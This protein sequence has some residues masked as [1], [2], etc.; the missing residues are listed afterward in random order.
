MF[1]FEDFGEAMKLMVSWLCFSA[2]MPVYWWLA[3]GEAMLFQMLRTADGWMYFAV[4]FL[5]AVV[6]RSVFNRL[7]RRGV[8]RS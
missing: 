4:C 5:L 7:V 3:Q 1:D 8:A 6:F 2:V